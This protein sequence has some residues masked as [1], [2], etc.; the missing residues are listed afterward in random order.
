MLFPPL[1]AQSLRR[2]DASEGG[3]REPIISA[4]QQRGFASHIRPEPSAVL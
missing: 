2:R 3:E 4:G 1:H